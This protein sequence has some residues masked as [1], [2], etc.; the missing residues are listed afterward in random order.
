MIF[1]AEMERGPVFSL[2]AK[3][4]WCQSRQGRKL[5][6]GCEAGCPS[7]SQAFLKCGEGSLFRDFWSPCQSLKQNLKNRCKNR[8]C[9]SLVL[10]VC[11]VEFPSGKRAGGADRDGWAGS[12]LGAMVVIANGCGKPVLGS[13]LE[14]L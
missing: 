10:P 12:R 13:M 4:F 7:V 2:F 9:D 6:L 1:V 8:L 11:V 5:F 3:V 14:V